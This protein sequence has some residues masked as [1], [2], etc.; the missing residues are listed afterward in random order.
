M[1]VIYLVLALFCNVVCRADALANV[2]LHKDFQTLTADNDLWVYLAKNCK[3]ATYSCIKTSV[4]DY[5]KSVLENPGDVQFTSF[6]RFPRNSFQYTPS[7]NSSLPEVSDD[8]S[9]DMPLQEVSRSLAST[10][11]T[12]FMT[13]DVEL[14]LPGSFFLGSVLKVSPR[15][16][17]S[18]STVLK[19]ELDTKRSDIT[20]VGEGRIFFKKIREYISERLLYALLALLLV[21]K[22]L[23]V[24]LLFVLPAIIGAAAAKKLILKVLLFLFPALHHL[25]KLCAY[26][27]YGAKHHIHKHQ[28]AHIHA[29]APHHHHHPPHHHHG[30]VEV[31]A[32]VPEYHYDRK[33]HRPPHLYEGE[34]EPPDDDYGDGIVSHHR[35]D[36]RHHETENEI[37]G[38]GQGHSSASAT[39]R[40]KPPSS[41]A[42]PTP[43]EIESM[44]LKAEKEAKIKLRLQKERERIHEEN[45]R[46][47]DQLNKELKLQAK[48]KHYV[49]KH[50]LPPKHPHLT[51]TRVSPPPSGLQPPRM[52]SSHEEPPKV[53]SSFGEPILSFD[54]PPKGS[55]SAELPSKGTESFSRPPGASAS[56]AEPPE[57]YQVQEGESGQSVG[58]VNTIGV[59]PDLQATRVAQAIMKLKQQA[60]AQ[61]QITQHHP[62]SNELPPEQTFPQYTQAI[63][64]QHMPPQQ[65]P[66]DRKH[67]DVASANPIEAQFETKKVD[68]RKPSAS[69]IEQAIYSAASI[70]YDPFY[71]PILKQIDKILNELQFTEEPCKER[72]ICSMYK[73]PQKFS[74]HS[75]LISAELSRD[76]KELKK[77]KS[78]NAA[79]IRFYKY[80][81][82]ARDGQN[83]KDCLKLYSACSINT[84]V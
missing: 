58:V 72:L 28:I 83:Q 81:Q 66:I 19:L 20:S 52:I 34:V 44:L 74:P 75:N 36:H 51:K 76:S 27:P 50:K 48:L 40:P 54:E 53:Q 29:I 18:N 21:I 41:A 35:N 47:Q 84:E 16:M 59:N 10:T 80:I 69:H 73:R 12:F 45:L 55:V 39:R 60:I 7:D 5:L 46:I 77:P 33:G 67:F 14:S 22:F 64:P 31:E 32:E 65:T 30:H 79:V 24:K 78:T 6:L 26:T 1:Y 56:F 43:T 62:L 4:Y 11:K 9:H 61:P 49:Y 25:F 63:I 57:G 23:A 37:D 3:N 8:D 2:T 71:S 68:V 42:R 13:H 15:S 17:D 82:A 70:T 38:W